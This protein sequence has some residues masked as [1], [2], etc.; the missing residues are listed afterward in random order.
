MPVRL[1]LSVKMWAV[2]VLVVLVP[3][4]PALAGC[5]FLLTAEH[6]ALRVES[7]QAVPGMLSVLSHKRADW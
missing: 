7:S 6:G 3:A 2:G 4:S 5:P 1:Q